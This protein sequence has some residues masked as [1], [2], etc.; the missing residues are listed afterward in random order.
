MI[1]E[2][3]QEPIVQK[4]KNDF[5]PK[6]FFWMFLGLLGTAIVAWYTYSSGL[7]LNILTNDSFGILLI[8]EVIVV[9]VFSF[10]FRKL[11]PTIVGILYF[12]Y[13]AIN[14]VTLSTIF[15][16]FKLNSI[17][18]LF[19]A[20]SVLFGGLALYGYNTSKDLS[21]WRT[22]L[23]G[24]LIVGLIVSLI[25]LFI[26]NTMLDLILDWVILLVF[27]GITAYDINKIKQ[28]YLL[29][30]IDKNKLHIYGAMEL[31]LDFINIFLRILSIFGKRRN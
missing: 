15:Y 23:F 12:I 2:E 13:A 7:S 10:L 9:L 25:N 31:Y 4:A 21:N 3:N 18:L 19:I 11:S 5:I 6:T 1:G 17:V 28:L 8:A 16:V 22:V 27:F 26:G 30:D 20:S 14:G 24:T 29:D